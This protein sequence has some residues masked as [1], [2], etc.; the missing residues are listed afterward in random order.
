MQPHMLCAAFTIIS[1]PVTD[2]A[3]GTNRHD[4]QSRTGALR[5]SACLDTPRAG[6]RVPARLTGWPAMSAS[7]RWIHATAADVCA[8]PGERNDAANEAMW[9]DSRRQARWPVRSH[10]ATSAVRGSRDHCRF[11]LQ[12]V[13]TKRWADRRSS[14]KCAAR[15]WI[16]GCRRERI[17][18]VDQRTWHVL[19][20]AQSE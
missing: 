2:S 12:A 5:P 8:T 20:R 14:R 9:T 6:V 11:E 15:K 16:P 19:A 4:E 7:P 13:M 17:M 18:T 3:H 1:A 10:D